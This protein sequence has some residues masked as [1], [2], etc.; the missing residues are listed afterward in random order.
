MTS[1]CKNRVIELFRKLGYIPKNIKQ[2]VGIMKRGK[3]QNSNIRNI[4]RY[5][6]CA[7]MRNKLIMFVCP[8]LFLFGLT[9]FCQDI[10]TDFLWESTPIS[11]YPG[12]PPSKIGQ[13]GQLVS[14]GPSIA[15][16]I[17]N[18]DTDT[19]SSRPGYSFLNITD[20]NK[21][22]LNLTIPLPWAN[23]NIDSICVDR[24]SENWV[25]CAN[26]HIKPSRGQFITPP[27]TDFLG[28]GCSVGISGIGLVVG[29]CSTNYKNAVGAGAIQVFLY[30]NKA[31]S[32]YQNGIVYDP[33]A[34]K[35]SRFGCSVA[36]GEGGLTAIIGADGFDE[37]T[38]AAYLYTMPTSQWAGKIGIEFGSLVSG[39]SQND[40]FGSCVSINEKG[41][42][43]VVA[44]SNKSGT[45]AVYV[46]IKDSFG[47]WKETIELSS[48]LSL[49]KGDNFGC[50]ISI[51][52][53][54]II[55]G[56]D[57]TSNGSGAAYIFDFSSGHWVY[58]VKKGNKGQH[59]GCSVSIFSNMI[60]IGAK[61]Y[62]ENSGAVFFQH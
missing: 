14:I 62:N 48:L 8:F 18:Q 22:V 38:G 17:T 16:T 24:G 26:G 23:S 28:Y 4:I 11:P 44:A 3:L 6:I 25:L 29:A 20:P 50:S 15:M 1:Y 49:N 27:P 35:N 54:K 37:N 60:V 34:S 10:T 7:I 56:A 52:G 40:H 42:T 32:W 57:G 61:G 19:T 36:V 43:A 51:S 58:T 9:A 12:P 45:G 41:D 5:E 21:P 13:W 30:S 33:A 53:K 46:F 2:G 55:V 39:L 47:Y 59:Y 31:K